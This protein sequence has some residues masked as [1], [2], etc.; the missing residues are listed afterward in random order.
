MQVHEY[1]VYDFHT[2]VLSYNCVRFAHIE[3]S[4]TTQHQAQ[5]TI[6]I[7]GSTKEA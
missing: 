6:G 4:S 3:W 7:R 5:S 1:I 2:Y